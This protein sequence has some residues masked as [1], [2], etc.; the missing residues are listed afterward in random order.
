QSQRRGA[1]LVEAAIVYPIL[2]LLL[3]GVVVVGLGVFRYNQVASL[4]R[5]GARLASVRGAQYAKETG[6]TAATAT[7]IRDYILSKAVGLDT[8]ATTL[9]VDV[10][11]ANTDTN[12]QHWPTYTDAGSKKTNTVT[13]TVTYTW[14]PEMYLAGPITLKS[15]SVMPMSF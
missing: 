12:G 1:V 2:L 5:E 13:V 3:I 6:K 10:S 14:M 11:W 7:D 8:S 15:T 9:T 4:A